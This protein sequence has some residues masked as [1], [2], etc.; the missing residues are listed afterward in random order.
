MPPRTLSLNPKQLSVLRIRLL[1][2]SL[3]FKTR[4]NVQFWES[5]HR[6]Q[7]IL[8]TLRIYL[9]T[10]S[11]SFRGRSSA[12]N[13]WEMWVRKSD[14]KDV[15]QKVILGGCESESQTWKIWVGESDWVNVSQKSQTGTIWVLTKYE[16]S[17]KIMLSPSAKKVTGNSWILY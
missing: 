3:S 13:L 5:I 9:N 7:T 10:N 6:T 1:V 4:N 17:D 16:V 15:S 12:A 14:W 11:P 2:P 8:K